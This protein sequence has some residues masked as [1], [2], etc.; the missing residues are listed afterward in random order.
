MGG[1][2]WIAFE[3]MDATEESIAG[4]VAIYIYIYL[5]RALFRLSVSPGVNMD[6]C[7]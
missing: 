6:N 2:K 4:T 5:S 3:E 7:I 1:R